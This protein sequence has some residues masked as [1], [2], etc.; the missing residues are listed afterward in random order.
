MNPISDTALYTCLLRAEDAAQAKPICNDSY[1]KSFLN[2]KTSA[3]AVELK[4]SKQN[5]ETIVSRHRIID[6]LLRTQLAA[7][8][9]TVVIIVGCGFDTRAFRL[10]G[11]TWFEI[12]E[13]QV[14]DY[15]NITLPTSSCQNPLQRIAI[16]F[17][18]TSLNDVLPSIPSDRPIFVVIEGVFL[19]LTEAQIDATLLALH[20][21]YANHTMVC[22][23]ATHQV[24][25][26]YAKNVRQDTEQ[27]GGTWRFFPVNP[28]AHFEERGYSVR[29]SVSIVEKTWEYTNK[30]RI[31]RGLIRCLLPRLI[32]G[33]AVHVFNAKQA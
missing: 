25:T 28:V 8:P 7:E 27:L 10:P 3:M 17:S 5:A 9:D 4:A 32:D 12:D 21:A 33:L 6:D 29:H 30:S 20:S 2:S 19:Y 22:E 18:T 26:H 14:I 1:A 23:L 31:F 16:D 24:M 11:G 15:K 13:P